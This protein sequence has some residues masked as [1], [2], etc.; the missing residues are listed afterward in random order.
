MAT[1]IEELAKYG[2]SCLKSKL[3]QILD[4]I[5]RGFPEES[6][7]KHSESEIERYRGDQIAKLNRHVESMTDHYG[8]YLNYGESILVKKYCPKIKLK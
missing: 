7:R 4:N 2:E 3:K 6:V 5:E 8:V 1:E